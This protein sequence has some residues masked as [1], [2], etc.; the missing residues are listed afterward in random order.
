MIRCGERV[1]SGEDET[2]APEKLDVE[3]RPCSDI[4]SDGGPKLKTQRSKNAFAISAAHT[5]L[6]EITLTSLINRSVTIEM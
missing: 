2:N 3:W 6:I 4:N 1:M 5:P